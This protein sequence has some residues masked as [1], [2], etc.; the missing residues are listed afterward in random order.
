M[1]SRRIVVDHQGNFPVLPG[2]T[3]QIQHLFDSAGTTL[4]PVL[5]GDNGRIC[6]IRSVL[7]AAE[8]DRLHHS[9]TLG[10]SNIGEELYGVHP[11]L[12]F[13]PVVQSLGKGRNGMEHRD[14]HFAKELIGLVLGAADG[15]AVETKPDQW[16]Q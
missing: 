9:V 5:Y 15:A 4:R 2:L 10:K 14:I 1:F 7:F 11:L 3:L 16:D 13:F 8:D 12:I 6:L